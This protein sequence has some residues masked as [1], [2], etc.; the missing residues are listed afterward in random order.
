[1]KYEVTY[2]C[3]KFDI[4]PHDI[5]NPKEAYTPPKGKEDPETHIPTI[6]RLK[7]MKLLRY[8]AA[9][10]AYIPQV[11]K[12][13]LT[14]GSSILYDQDLNNP[15]IPF[16]AEDWSQ[17]RR[18]MWH[19]LHCLVASLFRSVQESHNSALKTKAEWTK[20][21][22]T[23]WF[24]TTSAVV[25]GW[26]AALQGE[27]ATKTL[28]A[29]ARSGEV[30]LDLA[31][32]GFPCLRHNHPEW[33]WTIW[34]ALQAMKL[35]ALQDSIMIID[36]EDEEEEDPEK[37]KTAEENENPEEGVEKKKTDEAGETLEEDPEKKK[38]V[39]EDELMTGSEDEKKTASGTNSGA[40]SEDKPSDEDVAMENS[41]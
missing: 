21:E 30:K 29:L 28:G 11:T 41:D 12:L 25:D 40:S 35:K 34:D 23:N 1:M 19:A 7:W 32:L 38:T 26:I 3:G 9:H 22:P 39:E 8:M 5:P 4:G 24:F 33:S 31:A 36:D 13:A 14:T 10:S 17:D 15:T 27:P 16:L 37:K 18:F 2:A 6:I 20:S